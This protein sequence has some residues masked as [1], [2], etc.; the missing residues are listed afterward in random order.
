M[1]GHEAF[2]W[3]FHGDEKNVKTFTEEGWNWTIFTLWLMLQLYLVVKSFSFE[4]IIMKLML[5]SLC[6]VHSTITPVFTG[7]HLLENKYNIQHKGRMFATIKPNIMTDY[8]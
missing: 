5:I 1:H 7:S 6:N 3:Y 2:L 4:L 8:L